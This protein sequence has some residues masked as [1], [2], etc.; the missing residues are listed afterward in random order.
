MRG[1]QGGVAHQPLFPKYERENRLA[2]RLVV[3]GSADTLLHDGDRGVR[4]DRPV[5]AADKLVAG[6]RCLEQDH[7]AV[8]RYTERR[9]DRGPGNRVVTDRLAALQQRS[10]PV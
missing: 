4:T 8:A 3:I 7:L 5:L 1:G 6:L 2:E 10:I 9:A